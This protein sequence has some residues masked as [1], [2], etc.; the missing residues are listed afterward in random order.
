MQTQ[1][2]H[3]LED[4][5]SKLR[6]QPSFGR[7]PSVIDRFVRSNSTFKQEVRD[8]AVKIEEYKRDVKNLENENRHLLNNYTKTKEEL[9]ALMQETELIQN[10]SN[11]FQ[12][13]YKEVIAVL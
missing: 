11:E 2:L 9:E 8:F 5:I 13:L 6:N 12:E 4:E 3:R 10:E 1:Q 7:S